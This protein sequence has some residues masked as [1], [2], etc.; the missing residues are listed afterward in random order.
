MQ[1]SDSAINTKRGATIARTPELD[2]LHLEADLREY[3]VLRQADFRPPFHPGVAHGLLLSAPTT[4]I[5]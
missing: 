2:G 5:G 4:A 1:Q 3:I